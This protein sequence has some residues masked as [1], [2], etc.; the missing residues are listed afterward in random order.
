MSFER[1]LLE[2]LCERVDSGR[3]YVV[4]AKEFQEAVQSLGADMETDQRVQEVMLDC[5][6]DDSGFVDFS[7]FAEG[8]NKTNSHSD[9]TFYRLPWGNNSTRNAS[10]D[11]ASLTSAPPNDQNK[12][13]QAVKNE[14]V[15]INDEEETKEVAFNESGMLSFAYVNNVELRALK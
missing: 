15:H 9:G 4:H 7:K 12:A 3:R 1:Q 14:P 6:I 11:E 13:P 8:L 2:A 5:S 10:G